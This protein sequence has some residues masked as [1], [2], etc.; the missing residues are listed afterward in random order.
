VRGMGLEFQPRDATG[1]YV[2]LLKANRERIHK[3]ARDSKVL[4]SNFGSGCSD[5]EDRQNELIEAI[6]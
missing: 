4:D 2:L 6:G 3:M 5:C 1:E